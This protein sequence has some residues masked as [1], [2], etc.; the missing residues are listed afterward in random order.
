[1]SAK[2]VND[3]E[4][5]KGIFIA[6]MGNYELCQVKDAITPQ[7]RKSGMGP[8]QGLLCRRV[9]TV[10]DDQESMEQDSQLRG[11]RNDRRGLGLLT[12]LKFRDCHTQIC[13]RCA[14]HAIQT[15]NFLAAWGQWISRD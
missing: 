15:V 8:C 3:D 6:E 14:D 7:L 13:I 1:V 11:H 2:V 12:V 5:K 9:C 4:L 10:P